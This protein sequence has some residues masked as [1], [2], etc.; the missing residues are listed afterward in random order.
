MPILV[1]TILPPEQV[2]VN[3]LEQGACDTHPNLN[4]SLWIRSEFEGNHYTA[5]TLNLVK[6][7]LSNVP[8]ELKVMK[9][10]ELDHVI[11]VRNL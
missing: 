6:Q 1:M 5:E 2:S 8:A 3:L 9:H 10:I 11:N 4:L 7:R